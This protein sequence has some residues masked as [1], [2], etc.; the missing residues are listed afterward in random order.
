[1]KYFIPFSNPSTDFFLPGKC[2]FFYL[3]AFL[4]FV[5]CP[6]EIHRLLPTGDIHS[7]G[8]LG[9]PPALKEAKRSYSQKKYDTAIKQ[10]TAYA[11]KNPNDGSPFLY[12]GYIYESRKDF[13]KSISMFRR[14]VEGRLSKSQ[15]KTTLLKLALYYDYYQE[16]D[17]AYVYSSRYLKMNPN[18]K[19]VRKIQE[20]GEAN[21]GKYPSRIAYPSQPQTQEN[22]TPPK[23]KTKKEYETI[24]QSDPKNEEALW[25]L[26]MIAFNAKD[27]KLAEKY[28]AIL[29]D[30]HS[31]KPSYSYKLGVTRIRLEKY[32]KS[33]DDFNLAKN[34]LPKDD[35][36]FQYYLYLNEGIS[37]YKLNRLTEAE[38]S[39]KTSYSKKPSLPPLIVLTRVLHRAAKYDEC[40]VKSEKVMEERPQDKENK[41]YRALCKYDSS[42]KDAGPLYAFEKELRAEYPQAT[43]IPDTY[44]PALIKLARDYTNAEKYKEA[45]EYYGVLEKEYGSNREYLFYRG[46]ALYY[47]GNPAK[48]IQY[49]QKVERS[50]AAIYLMAKA[51]AVL[52]NRTQ[53]EENLLLAGKTKPVYWDLA[54]EEDDFSELRKNPDFRKFLTSQGKYRKKENPTKA[55]IDPSEKPTS[56]G[57]KPNE[58]KTEEPNPEESRKSTS[59]QD[60]QQSNKANP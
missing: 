4:L 37:L 59:S 43:S 9:D 11:D 7:Q 48:S 18:N 56:N 2:A 31:N 22:P 20:R 24:L 3:F 16:Y 30:N 8:S 32:K 51:Y 27:Y 35:T 12:M 33:L 1:M 5:L 41:M 54:L 6:P 21:R 34:H 46:K 44:Y 38:A 49:L 45:E 57:S 17:L 52:G 15:K 23:K 10:F 19:E 14:A 29:V 39:L 36:N 60:R 25:E 47:S 58:S 28:F 50:T 26:G 40:V 42:E 13:P 55:T 53:T